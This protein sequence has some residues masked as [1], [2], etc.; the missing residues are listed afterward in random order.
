MPNH[1]FMPPLTLSCEN[2]LRVG[3]CQQWKQ[4]H[5]FICPGEQAQT[6]R[7]KAVLLIP[8]ESHIIRKSFPGVVC[9]PVSLPT[10]PMHPRTLF[11]VFRFFLSSFFFVQLR[12]V[13]PPGTRTKRNK[14][15]QY[16]RFSTPFLMGL[17][18]VIPP[19]FVPA[20]SFT[21]QRP[22]EIPRHI[23]SCI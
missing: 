10:V 21:P 22:E 19:R 1:L 14:I 4:K 11:G 7:T 3:G 18:G 12:C 16:S 8:S 17:R 2:I 15:L 23:P 6:N 20:H 13:C 9:V 5:L